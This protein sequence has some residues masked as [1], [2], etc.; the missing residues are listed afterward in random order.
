MRRASIFAIIVAAFFTGQAQ[1]PRDISQNWEDVLH[2]IRIARF[3]LAKAYGQL[4]V[5]GQ[6][7]PEI[8]YQ[9]SAKSPQDYQ[10]LQRASTNAYDKELAQIAQK[11]LALIEQ[12]RQALRSDPKVIRQEIE[13]LLGQSE[14]GTAMAMQRLR[15]SGEY[16]VPFILQAMSDPSNRPYVDRLV[17]ALAYVGGAA[18]RPLCAAIVASDA[19]IRAEVVRAL[20]RIASFEVLP[21]LKYVTE[22]DRVDEIR[23]IA[24][25]GI[26]QVDPSVS[27]NSAASLFYR[28]ATQYYQQRDPSQAAGFVNMWF[29]D[30]NTQGL[31]RRPVDGRYF[32]DLMAMSCCQWALKADP[33]YSEAV[34][35][36]AAAFIRA[37]SYGIGL[38]GFLPHAQPGPMVFATATGTRHLLQALARALNDGDK[39]VALGVL[40]ALAFT[41]G[42]RTALNAVGQIQPLIEALR[43]DYMPV[44]TVAA[45]VIA[46]AR[47]NEPFGA[48]GIV[49]EDL[50]SAIELGADPNA[51]SDPNIIGYAIRSLE[52][53]LAIASGPSG[54]YDLHPAQQGLM[55]A[56]QRGP[57]ALRTPAY[58]VLAYI[59]TQQAQQTLAI[60]G[61][62]ADNDL[63]QRIVALES[64]GLSARLN[65]CLLDDGLLDRLLDLVRSDQADPELRMAAAAALGCMDL[66]S[67]RI[68]DLIL[69]G[70]VD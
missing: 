46:S 42:P 30:P 12:G 59:A 69:G 39:A 44:R 13:R 31:V 26:M 56:A 23:A 3:D 25:T 2:Y 10:L 36:W 53:M 48:S 6:V 22:T 34:G 43:S 4:L 17:Q 50:A 37:Q 9:L 20:G 49:V 51:G 58:R 70:S 45:I 8:L 21:Y 19:P 7:E 67:A 27:A 41:T 65:G 11:V 47:L 61:L 35:L 24:A 55:K 60:Q 15:D 5:E 62:A 18:V 16:A 38:P 28:L 32:N 1:G 40:E 54:V 29:W 52:A 57:A 63:D 66:P 64:L 68:R 14:R 33:G